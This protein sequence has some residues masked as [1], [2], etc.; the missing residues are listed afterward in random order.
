MALTTTVRLVRGG[1]GAWV[2]TATIVSSYL[3]GLLWHLTVMKKAWKNR[4]I[5]VFLMGALVHAVML[6][7]QLLLPENAGWEMLQV[8]WLPVMLIYPSGTVILSLLLYRQ[9]DQRV[10]V[11][12]VTV[13]E[14]KY[15]SLFEYNLAAMLLIEPESSQIIGANAAASSFYGW[16]IP[17]LLTMFVSDINTLS[18]EEV[19][20]ELKAAAQMK[21]NYF[22]FRH[23]LANGDIRD[24]EIYSSTVTIDG[25]PY[26]HSIIHDVTARVQA[27]AALANALSALQSERDRAE[28]ANKA[29]S[30]FLAS[31]S[32]EI[33]TPMN[34]ILG[35]LQLLEMTPLSPDQSI[36]VGYIRSSTDMLLSVI[37]SILDF[38][39]ADAERL[40]LESTAFS[41]QTAIRDSVLA[42]APKAAEK[43]VALDLHLPENLPDTVYGDAFRL[44]Q[45]LTN[46][47]S[48]AVKFTDQGRI[49][50]QA[51]ITAA[52]DDHCELHVSVTDT[53]IGISP[54]QMALLFEP[55]SQADASITRKYGGTGLGL[56]LSK[57]LVHLMGGRI[58]VDSTPSK[59]ST[60]WISVPYSKK[61]LGSGKS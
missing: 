6:A 21:Q 31:M 8:I 60:F 40:V 14:E 12:R 2:G 45:I 55:F 18:A 17:Q 33:R 61:P 27:E 47:T 48:N 38:S 20:K 32:H 56:A 53:G 57:R 30:N 34:G 5:P 52:S 3:I 37:N 43:G 7:W 9:Q 16:S 13:A 42:F 25:T 58:G 1:T 50:V 24:V 36:Q 26:L 15:R 49:L 4:L 39:K 11:Q 19:K 28:E 59:G 22:Q 54:E 44:K 51:D 10:A 46:L 41:L 29:K 35:F 23:R